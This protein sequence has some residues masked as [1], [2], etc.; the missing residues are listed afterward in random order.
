M[1]TGETWGVR[2]RDTA[3]PP[4]PEPRSAP[5]P[6]LRVGSV[7]RYWENSWLCEITVLVL[8][9]SNLVSGT[10][11]CAHRIREIRDWKVDH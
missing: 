9:Q 5:A 1:P 7:A 11:L 8:Y 4:Q 3:V 2:V 6:L 10:I